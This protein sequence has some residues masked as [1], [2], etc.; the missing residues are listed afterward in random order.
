MFLGQSSGGFGNPLLQQSDDRAVSKHFQWDYAGT[1][2]HLDPWADGMLW[3]RPRLLG[4]APDG[5]FGTDQ[6]N[7]GRYESD[8]FDFCG[9]AQIKK[10]IGFTLDANGDPLGSC[11]IQG[12]LTV[13]D[14]YIGQTISDTAGYYELPTPYTGTHYIVAYKAGSPDVAGT[15]VNTLVPV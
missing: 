5:L 7:S 2:S 4:V 12:F 6:Q 10:I 13:N 14:L 1:R 11:I 8:A 9:G 15:S 3:P